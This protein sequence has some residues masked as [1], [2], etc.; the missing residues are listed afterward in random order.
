MRNF[1]PGRLHVLAALLTGMAMVRLVEAMPQD[2]TSYFRFVW[3]MPGGDKSFP[4]VGM[5]I[6]S[7]TSIYEFNTIIHSNGSAINVDPL[8]RPSGSKTS[9]YRDRG[10]AEWIQADF[11][12]S[13]MKKFQ[14]AQGGAHGRNPD[15]SLTPGGGLF[16]KSEYLGTSANRGWTRVRYNPGSTKASLS[17]PFAVRRTIIPIGSFPESIISNMNFPWATS[18]PLAEIGISPDRLLY[19]QAFHISDQFTNYQVMRP[20]NQAS[21]AGNGS[22]ASAFSVRGAGAGNFTFDMS[23]APNASGNTYDRNRGYITTEYRAADC[24]DGFGTLLTSSTNVGNRVVTAYTWNGTGYASNTSYPGCHG[25]RNGIYVLE[26]TGDDIYN[27]LDQFRFAHKSGTGNKEI[28]VRIDQLENT[29]GWARAGIMIRE[30]TAQN[31]RNVAV[32]LTPGNGLIFQAR[33]SSTSTATINTRV[34]SITTAPLWLRLRYDDVNDVTRA[35][36]GTNGSTWTEVGNSFLIANFSNFQM[37]LASASR[38]AFPHT[39][40]FSNLTISDVLSAP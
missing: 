40:V 22:L 27:S 31:A 25:Y 32:F 15:G 30:G 3:S 23:V 29:N 7:P 12:I 6:A 18:I 38:S 37:G 8:I 17:Q 10:G 5:G 11:N 26:S 2:S 36:Y 4:L 34:S 20:F 9:L 1:K 39:S 16:Y 24:A 28:K 13:L 14:W 33:T 35:Y 21:N 19:I